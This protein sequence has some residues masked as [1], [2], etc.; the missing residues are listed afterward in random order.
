MTSGRGRG[1]GA[2]ACNRDDALASVGYQEP[3]YRIRVEPAIAALRDERDSRYSSLH[4][5]VLLVD[6][7]WP[8]L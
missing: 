7:N 5:D 4:V 8:L 6:G 3:R 1:Q 2:A